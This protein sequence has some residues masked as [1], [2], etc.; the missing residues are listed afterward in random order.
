MYIPSARLILQRRDARIRHGDRQLAA[1]FSDKLPLH[2]YTLRKT[3]QL[4]AICCERAERKKRE[5]ERGRD[6]NAQRHECAA[7][8]STSIPIPSF[9]EEP[10]CARRRRP[11]CRCVRDSHYTAEYFIHKRAEQLPYSTNVWSAQGRPRSPLALALALARLRTHAVP[12]GRCSCNYAR[13]GL[14]YT[15][16]ETRLRC[17]FFSSFFLLFR[18][19]PFRIFLLFVSSSP[20]PYRSSPPLPRRSLLSDRLTFC[21]PPEMTARLS[22]DRV[23]RETNSRDS[24]R[25]GCSCRAR[26][27]SPRARFESVGGRGGHT[28]PTDKREESRYTCIYARHRTQSRRIQK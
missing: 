12:R 8:I 25:C 16:N 19:L 1:L 7:S 4:D 26:R 5:R 18:L 10:A 28:T 13:R 21:M 11:V 15:V 20:L 17:R 23:S 3:G 2:L 22:A 14:R 24:A 27:G 9:S 6:L